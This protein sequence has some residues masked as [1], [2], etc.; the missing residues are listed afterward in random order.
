MV[1][2]KYL[3][4]PRATESGY[5]KSAKMHHPNRNGAA[6]DEHRLAS[7]ISTATFC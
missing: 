2:V 1:Q 3:L 4:M 6:D 5:T 7:D